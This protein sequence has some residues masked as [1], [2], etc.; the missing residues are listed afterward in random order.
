MGAVIA[1]ALLG[2]TWM[3]GADPKASSADVQLQ[4][5][6]HTEMVDGNFKVAIEKYKKA[7]QTSDRAVAA[8]ALVRLAECYQKLGD[9][10][11][12]KVY[13]RVLREY[14]EQKGAVAIARAKLGR[15]AGEADLVI[16]QV[17]SGQDVNLDGA[18]SPDGRYIAFVNWKTRGN[19]ALRDLKTGE[20]RDLT[21]DTDGSFAEAAV[22]MPDGN[23]ILYAWY[24]DKTAKY[25][26]RM[27]A[28]NGTNIREIADQEF[29]P[30]SVSRDGKLAAG[31]RY[32]G[33]GQ[34]QVSVLEM[35]SGRLTNLKSVGWTRPAIGN[36]S[37]DGRFLAYSLPINVDSED[38]NVYAIAVDG[39][40]ETVLIPA[41][42]AN[43]RPL[44]T[45]DGSRV[46]LASNRASRWDLWAVPMFV[47]KA[48][49]T[50]EVIK[51]DIGT[52]RCLG[53][54][55]DG[56]LYFGALTRQTEAYTMGLDPANWQVNGEPKRVTQRLIDIN[57]AP[58]WSPD[59]KYLAYVSNRRS[60]TDSREA[61]FVVRDTSSLEEREYPVAVRQIQTTRAF[62]WFPDNQSLLLSEY[63]GGA[64]ARFR[65]LDLRDGKVTTLFQPPPGNQGF[66]AAISADGRAL[67]YGLRDPDSVDAQNRLKVPMIR[68]AKRDLET[69]QE[70]YPARLRAS[71]FPS[72]AT[73]PDGRHAAFYAYCAGKEEQCLWAVPLTGGD[74]HSIPAPKGRFVG[75]L[76]IAWAPHSEGVFATLTE[77]SGSSQTAR[78]EIWYLPL[79]GKTP[80][81]IKVP[82][83]Q[84]SFPA[85]HPSGTFLGFTENS[86][87]GYVSV[88]QNLFR[89]TAPAR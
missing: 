85:V 40:S 1:A 71:V 15:D 17:W 72:I 54:A 81:Q 29:A 7:A 14:G 16:R 20:S 37:P 38:S 25:T 57:A 69:G 36:F 73:S 24:N 12:K 28:M 83:R 67:L 5:A 53:F 55:N 64:N 8:Q 44:F 76:G 77:E 51:A 88:I 41:P 84:V 52:V 79:D 27:I 6:I 60:T 56:S 78:T 68:L 86:T 18:P 9:T 11:S 35:A 66:W 2:G 62:R 26:V 39:A 32:A 31:Y 74:P 59:G 30:F 19:L 10:E 43:G 87:S 23:G 21:K 3:F 22:F 47:G 48:S 70:T 13:E 65:R 46:V 34:R 33:G 45:P 49:G 63:V 89:R 42:G 61:T 58:V 75:G 82:M 4:A 80:H 50:P